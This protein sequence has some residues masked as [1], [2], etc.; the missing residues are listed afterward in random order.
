LSMFE[1]FRQTTE[2]FSTSWPLIDINDNPANTGNAA[3]A[4]QY[5]VDFGGGSYKT[6]HGGGTGAYGNFGVDD[7]Y[8]I[9]LA[10]G[11][12]NGGEGGTGGWGSLHPMGCWA[13]KDRISGE[14]C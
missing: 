9:H 7:P 14:T 6:K 12:D 2:L 5:G 13:M 8:P 1:L 3:G 4:W 11:Y 10:G